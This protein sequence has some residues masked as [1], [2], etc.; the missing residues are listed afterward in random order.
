MTRPASSS[1]IFINYLL[2]LGIGLIWGSQY[3][4]IKIALGSF[5]NAMVMA[6][7]V[8]IGASVLTLLLNLRKEH[9]SIKQPQRS[10]LSLLPEFILIGFFEATLPCFLIAW[11]QQQVPSSVTAILM[12]TV[13]LFATILEALFV[14]DYPISGKKIAAILTGFCG[15][16]V[17]IAPGLFASKLGFSLSSM[18][19][20]VPVI[21]LLFSSLCFAISV[22]LIKIRLG[23]RVAPLRA[24]QGILFGAT[25]TAIPFLF[26]FSKTW[27][28][29][30]ISH[31]SCLSLLLVG[32][33][34]GGVVYTLYVRLINRAGPSFASTGNYLALPIG[35]FMGIVIAQ[36]PFTSNV[37]A[38]FA[39]ILSALWLL[40]EKKKA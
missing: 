2:L 32:I 31:A 11:A 33:F 1:T 6:G 15:V 14:K 28:I 24:A 21:A 37:I 38:S 7:R 17:L 5:S 35:T 8:V 22:S 29:H 34:A 25:I 3:F 12:G 20:I 18:F 9:L 19:P 39:L 16:L 30:P 27:F 26:F 13:P 23:N 40:K 4:F 10:F 36:E